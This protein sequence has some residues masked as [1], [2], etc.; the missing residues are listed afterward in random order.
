MGPTDFADREILSGDFSTV[1][2]ERLAG[3]GM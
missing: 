1:K 2:A 3:G